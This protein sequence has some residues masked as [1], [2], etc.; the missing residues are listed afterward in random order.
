[1]MNQETTW[2][3]QNSSKEQ[4]ILEA[5]V[6]FDLLVTL[7]NDSANEVATKSSE[8]RACLAVSRVRC[9][10]SVKTGGKTIS[11]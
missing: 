10:W 7:G 3:V 8:E 4:D 5:A 2:S 6:V 11:F 9:G 1:M